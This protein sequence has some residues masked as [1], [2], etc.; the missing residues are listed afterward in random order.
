MCKICTEAVHCVALWTGVTLQVWIWTRVTLQVW[1]F[2]KYVSYTKCCGLDKWMNLHCTSEVSNASA[3]R[4]Q[5]HTSR[6]HENDRLKTHAAFWDHGG[7]P[8]INLCGHLMSQRF[9]EEFICNQQSCKVKMPAA[10]G[11]CKYI[12][13]NTFHWNIP[14]HKYNVNTK[15]P[16]FPHRNA[17][18]LHCIDTNQGG[19]GG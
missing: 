6:K 7:E 17:S 5:H 4:K 9:V 16:D 1:T 3:K 13:S 10:N 18:K 14:L 15:S 8:E 2:V 12:S 19:L 11:V